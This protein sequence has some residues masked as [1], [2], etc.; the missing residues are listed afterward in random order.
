MFASN[1]INFPDKTETKCHLH[2]AYH[3]L[4]FQVLFDVRSIVS[5]W[6]ATA[7]QSQK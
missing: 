6:S 3:I 4:I 2:L 7:N 1:L 5:R